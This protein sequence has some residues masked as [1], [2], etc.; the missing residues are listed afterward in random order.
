MGR[1]VFQIDIGKNPSVAE[2]DA[3]NPAWAAQWAVNYLSDAAEEIGAA[4]PN[5]SPGGLAWAVA[6]S[7]N[8]GVSGEINDIRKGLNPDVH[9]TGHNYGQDITHL[10]N[11]FH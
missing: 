2:G 8:H 3:M 9:T 5:L 6:A 4:L 1:G 10:M 11:C 7:W